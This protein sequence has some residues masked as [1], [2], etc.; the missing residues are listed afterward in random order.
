VGLADWATEPPDE[1][2]ARARLKALPP[3][4]DHAG[5]VLVPLPYRSRENWKAVFSNHEINQA[6]RDAPERTVPVWGLKAIQKSVDPAIVMSYVRGRRRG[7][8]DVHPKT[9][10][11]NDLPIVVSYRKERYV[12]DGHH[13]I[14]ATIVGGGSEVNARWVDL[15]ALE[16]ERDA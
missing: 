12:F 1:A 2:E 16:K 6:I 13:R 11:P 9:G 14:T 15:D 8:D 7:D 4:P 3:S 10:V 5:R